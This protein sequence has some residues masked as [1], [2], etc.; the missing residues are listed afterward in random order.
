[1]VKER[2]K[3]AGFHVATVYRWLDAYES[4]SKLDTLLPRARKDKDSYRLEPGVERIV[5]AVVGRPKQ[6]R[7]KRGL[8][9]VVAEIRMRCEAAGLPVPHENTV[10]RRFK[11]RGATLG[12]AE[13]SGWEAE[14]V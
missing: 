13:K 9:S 6:G 14:V 1:M 10:R 7:R 4:S 8:Q 12:R 3:L 11:D 2:A 5:Q